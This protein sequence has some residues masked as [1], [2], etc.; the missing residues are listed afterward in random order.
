MR[1]ARRAECSVCLAGYILIAVNPYK[2]L[3]CYSESE[4]KSYK[5]KSIGVLPPHLYAMADR[6]FRSMKVDGNCQSIVISGESGSGKTESSKIVMKYLAL[7]GQPPKPKGS[8][9]EERRASELLN[10]LSEKVLNCNPILEAFGNA[11]TVMNHNSSRFG[12]FTRIHFD[13]RNWLVGADIVT[14]LLEKSRTVT[15]SGEERNYHSF[16]QLFSGCSPAEKQ[17][18]KLTDPTQYHFLKDGVVHVDA[19]NDKER[20]EE[21]VLAMRSIGIEVAHQQG[22]MRLTAALLHL[23]NVEFVETDADSC[24]IVDL[25]PLQN[26]AE[27]MQTPVQNF[28]EGL[29]SRT[30]TQPMSGSNYKIPLK[31][32]EAR[33]SRDTLAKALYARMFDWLVVQINQSLLTNSETRAFIGVLDIFGFE[34]F[35]VNSFEQLCINFANEKLQAHFNQQVFRQEQEIYIREAIRWD[36][37]AEPNNQE[38]IEMIANKTANATTPV[39]LFAL[40]DE[41]CK[42]PKCTD[43]TFTEK[44]F[45]THKSAFSNTLLQH[46]PRGSG[47][48]N[49][50]GFVIRHYAGRVTYTSDGFRQKNNNMLHED[51]DLVLK[52]AEDPFVAHLV[53]Q[54]EPPPAPSS[55]KRAKTRFSS[56]SGHFSTQLISLTDTLQATSSHFVR[57]IN[58]NKKKNPNDFTGGHVLH[59]LRCSGMMEAL[60]LMHEGFPTRCPYEDLYD[61]YKE[62]MPRSIAELDSPSFCEILLLALGLDKSDYQLGITK[63]FFRA[64][65]LAFLDSLTGSEY[66]ELAPDIVNKVR[67]WL[68]K[69]RWRRHTIAVVAFLRLKRE[70][71]AR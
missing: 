69:K 9:A 25:Q 33:Y 26:A 18:L 1:S 66:K 11:K 60:R 31:V 45:Q 21:V 67:V 46:V 53:Q 14:Y 65:K 37:I 63:V 4:M 23:G 13:R 58:P 70:P 47:L 27:F 50:E 35:Q 24:K 71:S 5:G 41:Q 61:R 59:Q 57:C 42:L 48:L 30:M 16:Y 32:Q 8:D 68:I 6:A 10:T 52:S 51:L 56:V 62:M 12:K 29:V 36:P 22:V 64:G 20:H 54:T 15:Q 3:S 19:I 38:C 40:L 17:A 49:N 2:S 39:G 34:D 44:I 55:N 7:C 43:K 28:E